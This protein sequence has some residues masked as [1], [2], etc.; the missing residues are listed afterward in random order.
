MN[1]PRMMM[2]EGSR[3]NGFDEK[4]KQKAFWVACLVGAL[5]FHECSSANFEQ[6]KLRV[7][8]N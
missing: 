7:Q 1:E 6:S 4:Q 2:K 3:P 5:V 8:Q